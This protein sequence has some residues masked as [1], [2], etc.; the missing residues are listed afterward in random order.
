MGMSADGQEREGT[1][2][3]KGREGELHHLD[4]LSRGQWLSRSL[5]RG[6]LWE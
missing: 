1:V 2:N 6:V 3:E 5:L 4:D